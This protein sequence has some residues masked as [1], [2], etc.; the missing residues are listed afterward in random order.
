MW[1]SLWFCRFRSCQPV[2]CTGT[3][4]K[5][6]QGKHMLIYHLKQNTFILITLE[7]SN[8]KDEKI[9]YAFFIMTCIT[10]YIYSCWNF[11]YIN[12]TVF[13]FFFLTTNMKLETA[14]ILHVLHHTVK[15]FNSCT[16]QPDVCQCLGV[17]THM[18][19]MSWKITKLINDQLYVQLWAHPYIHAQETGW[20]RG[21]WL[22]IMP[23]LP[24]LKCTNWMSALYLYGCWNFLYW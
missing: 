22:Y 15:T 13:K 24:R 11:L 4:L 21:E 5:H 3:C 10:S 7:R 18:D 19:E 17:Q 20:Q 16:S 1:I 6:K 2:P 12:N 23:G 8:N 14:W 9:Q